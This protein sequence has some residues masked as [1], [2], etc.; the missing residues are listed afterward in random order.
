MGKP[1]V[2]TSSILTLINRRSICVASGL[3]CLL[4]VGCS[5][6]SDDDDNAPKGGSSTATGGSSAQSGGSGG[7]ANTG[8][9]NAVVGTFN[10]KVVPVEGTNRAYTAMEGA[11]ANGPKTPEHQF[12]KSGSP[13]NGCQ[14][15]KYITPFC[16][17]ACASSIIKCVQIDD[18]TTKFITD[19]NNQDIGPVTLKGLKDQTGAT[20][21]TVK[22]IAENYSSATFTD[23]YPACNEGDDVTVSAAGNSFI[24]AFSL[25]TKCI[26]P[27]EIPFKNF[28][29]AVDGKNDLKVQWSAPTK[30][31]ISKIYIK[32]EIAHHGGQKGKIECNTE[33][34]GS[35]TIPAALQQSLMA[36]GVA[37]FPSIVVRRESTAS[38]ATSVGQVDLVAFSDVE[39]Y[40]SIPGIESCNDENPCT[41]GKTCQTNATCQF[42]CTKDSECPSGMTCNTSAKTCR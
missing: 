32:L 1:I 7:S 15:Y 40:V 27:I 20:E 29:L 38:I 35:F 41:A 36:L 33:D 8:N 12:L 25:T 6:S 39:R 5:S 26:A 10:V 30:N 31:G 24:Q 17:P 42:A 34:T 22:A 23:P 11:V 19:G 16:D 37:G 9:A 13:V 2:S 4:A 21:F 14:L 28:E 3:L 18:V